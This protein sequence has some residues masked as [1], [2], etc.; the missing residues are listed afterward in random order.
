MNS[1]KID[2]LGVQELLQELLGTDAFIPKTDDPHHYPMETDTLRNVLQQS[3]AQVVFSSRK[4]AK[5]RDLLLNILQQ[6]SS[7]A[8]SFLRDHGLDTL[9]L[10]NYL[11]HGLGIPTIGSPADRNKDQ[12]NSPP[13]EVNNKEDAIAILEKFTTNLNSVAAEGKIDPVIGREAEVETIVLMTARRTKNNV[14][15]VGEPG[16][17]KC[18]TGNNKVKIRVNDALLEVINSM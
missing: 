11:S 17:G 2:Y 16:V 7:Y 9:M 18:L 12:E 6:D 14:I 15:M 1:L 5:P 10:K 3:V 8:A 4:E 13:K